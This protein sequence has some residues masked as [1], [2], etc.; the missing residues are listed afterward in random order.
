MFR[1]FVVISILYI[2]K[3]TILDASLNWLSVARIAN[4]N[5]NR[6]DERVCARL[7]GWSGAQ[8]KFC[9]EHY[10]YAEIIRKAAKLTLDECQSQFKSRRWNCSI[11]RVPNIFNKLPESGVRESSYLYALSSAALTYSITTACS[12]GRLIGCSCDESKKGRV[13]NGH[14]WSG[15]SDNINYGMA[16]AENFLDPRIKSR[17]RLLF[18]NLHNFEIGR[19]IIEKNMVK[20]CKCHGVSGSCEIKTC[21][22]AM[23]PFTVIAHKLKEKYDA[24]VQVE[25]VKQ[26]S[27]R[28]SSPVAD[29]NSN[30]SK[31]KLVPKNMNTGMGNGARLSKLDMVYLSSSPDYCRANPR[32]A[33]YGTRDRVCNRTSRGIDSCDLLCCGRPYVTR[34]ETFRY[35]CNCTF[36]WCCT[37]SC[38]ECRTV[39]QVTRCR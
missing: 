21:W 12:E 24:A 36:N 32:L 37:V 31:F 28:S 2:T 9:Q 6:T 8:K 15:C 30:N 4:L 17:T 19:K 22:R 18:L 33:F 14:M 10:D 3:F 35:K 39:Q 16:V 5:F 7:P 34:M 25:I 27:S 29:Y 26:V 20:Q 1:I 11:G 13:V 23:P 38:Q